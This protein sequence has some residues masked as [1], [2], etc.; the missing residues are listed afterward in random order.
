MVTETDP[1]PGEE[2]TEVYYGQEE[3]MK[4]LLQVMVNVKNNAIVCSDS[5]SPGFSMLVEPIKRGYMD[6]R[7]RGVRIRQIVE[8]TKD[9]LAYCKELTDYVELRHLDNVKGNMIV[10]ETEYVATPVLE[11]STVLPTQTIYSNNSAFIAQQRYFFETLWKKATPAEQVVWELE[12]GIFPLET[13]IFNDAEEIG[14]EIEDGILTN[15]HWYICSGFGGLELGYKKCVP[16]FKKVLEGKDHGGEKGGEGGRAS[17]VESSNN[18]KGRNNGSSTG[19]SD[20]RLRWITN[21]DKDGIGM[22]KFFLNLGIRIRYMPKVPLMQFGVGDKKIVATVEDYEHGDIFQ[23]AMISNEPNYVKHFNALF[24]ELWRSNDSID[25]QERIREL[26]EGIVPEFVEVVTDRIKATELFVEFAKSVSKEALIIISNPKTMERAAMLGIWDH[27]ATAANNGADIRIIISPLTVANN[28]KLI[29]EILPKAPTIKIVDA[30][31]DVDSELFILDDERYLRAEVQRIPTEKDQAEGKE[32]VV[33]GKYGIDDDDDDDTSISLSIGRTIYSNSKT[34]VAS[35]RSFFEILWRQI[36]V[37]EK[38]RIHDKM[39]TEFANIAAH[40]LRTPIQPI[41]GIVDILRQRQR[42]KKQQ[43]SPGG[44]TASDHDNNYN[45]TIE[46]T[47]KQIEILDR[48]AKRLQRLSSEIL[49]V[50]RIESGTLKLEREVMDINQKV[51]NVIADSA[52]LVPQGQSID[53]QFRPLF[54]DESGRPVPLL[55]NIDRLRMFQVISNLIVNAIRFSNGDP[56]HESDASS[57]KTITITT[58]RKD[59]NNGSHVILVSVKDRGMGISK[60]MLP[61]LF[62]K[63]AADKERGGTGLGLFIAKNMV[64]AHGGKIWAENNK[65]DKGGATFAFT[66]PAWEIKK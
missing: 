56:T 14:K 28:A 19:G 46:I 2:H 10:S 23:T 66:L 55:V 57:R 61:K 62:A 21:F 35:F 33:A 63:F 44:E 26:E 24:E 43:M 13:R 39:Q 65:D 53:I 32:E 45:N 3:A 20:S 42:L 64:E 58:E 51:K 50:A 31:T 59:D 9:N 37:Y 29:S 60:E 17:G 36:D 8:I 11:G 49:D 16:A 15:D 52:G 18:D 1:R 4:V 34:G 41:I 25:A 48:N 7:K 12:Q 5:N 40:E 22:V 30:G 47:D 6:L 27:L 38:L 54:V